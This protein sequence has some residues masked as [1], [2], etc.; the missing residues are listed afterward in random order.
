MAESGA[1]EKYN[2]RVIGV[3]PDAIKRGEDR[4]AFKQTMTE[5]G[6]EMPQS[7]IAY[8]VEDAEKIAGELGYPVVVRPAYTMGGTGGGLAYNIEEL[9]YNCQ[10]GYCCQYDRPGSYRRVRRRL[11]RT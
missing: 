8:S 7:K 1:L 4:L 10:P 9:R 5:I 2:V 11:G 3:E 6:I